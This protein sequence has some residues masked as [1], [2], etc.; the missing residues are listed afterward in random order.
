[1]QYA[2]ASVER[3]VERGVVARRPDRRRRCSA[4]RG[5]PRSRGRPRRPARCTRA[6]PA[7]VGIR[8]ARRASRR[9]RRSR[10]CSST[11]SPSRSPTSSARSAQAMLRSRVAAERRQVRLGRRRPARARGPRAA[12][13]STSSACTAG[14]VGLGQPA[15]APEDPREP[16]ERGALGPAVAELPVGGERVLERGEGLGAVVDHVARLGDAAPTGRHAPSGGRPPAKRS[17]RAHCAA[18]SRWAPSSS[19]RSAAAGA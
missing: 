13:S 16:A 19:A 10:R 11:R 9:G 14:G 1:M 15:R 3:A 6:A 18:A 7:P 17:A 2:A 4:R 12:A 8:R 5:R